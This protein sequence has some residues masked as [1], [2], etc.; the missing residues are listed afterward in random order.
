MLAGATVRLIGYVAGDDAIG[1]VIPGGISHTWDPVA[2]V[3]QFSGAA[4]VAQYQ[5]LL[6]SVTYK[7][8]R[9]NPTTS[10]RA[11]EFTISDGMAVSTPV[12]VSISVTAVNNPPTLGAPTTQ[13]IVENTSLVLSMASGNAITVGDV[14]A[15][16]NPE[17]VTLAATDGSFT[18]SETSG[19]NFSVGTGANDMTAVFTGTLGDINAALDGLTFV[20]AT[21]YAGPARID[22][23]INDRGHA[24]IGGPLTASATVAIDVA[25]L[26][27]PPALSLPALQTLVEGTELVFSQANSNGLVASD[28]DSAG[29][30]EQLSLSATG[31]TLRLAAT[32]GLHF[33][34]GSG[35]G[36]ATI[37]ISGTLADLNAAID[38]LIFTPAAGYSGFA[39][40]QVSINDQ[41]N[42]G[43]GGPLTAQ[44]VIGITITPATAAP[45]LWI[46]EGL[47]TLQDTP[48]V[49]SQSDG[50]GITLNDADA[51][52]G[53]DQ[54]ALTATGGTLTLASTAGLNFS[55]GAGT[56]DGNVTFSGTVA[57]LNAALDGLIFKPSTGY[58]GPATIQVYFAD[59]DDANGATPLIANGTV[60]INI[61]PVNHA[62]VLSQDGIA[63]LPPVD[64]DAANPPGQNVLEMISTG[65]ADPIS[66]IDANSLQ[67]IAI[68]GQSIPAGGQWQFMLPGGAWMNLGDV[69][70]TGATLLP[71]SASVRFIPPGQ[72]SGSATLSYRA[73]DQTGGQPGDVQAD[74]TVNGGTSAFSAATA[75]ASVEVLPAAAPLPPELIVNNGLQAPPAASAPITASMLQASGPTGTP[76]DVIFT[77]TIAPAH[78]YLKVGTLR[79]IAGT[80][81]TQGDINSGRVTYASNNAGSPYDDFTFVVSDSAGD[82][83]APA[84]FGIHVGNARAL[85]PVIPALPSASIGT[86]LGGTSSG[87]TPSTAAGLAL[88]GASQTVGSGNPPE[89]LLVAGSDVSSNGGSSAH[90]TSGSSAAL[91]GNSADRAALALAPIVAGAGVNRPLS[92]PVQRALPGAPV[93]AAAPVVVPQLNL[94]LANLA[95]LGTSQHGSGMMLLQATV[96]P[97]EALTRLA[98]LAGNHSSY[99]ADGTN[100]YAINQ[101]SPFWRDL[102]DMQQQMN[103]DH[104]LRIVAGSAAISVG[105]SVMY[106]V[107]V[108]RAGSILSSFLSSMPA[109]RLVDPLPILDSMG[110]PSGSRAPK[111]N[112]EEDEDDDQTLESLVEGR[113]RR[114]D[115]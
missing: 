56:N 33:L 101:A 59:L 99:R 47:S 85:P 17:Q 103:A 57:D 40:I 82:S 84:V 69:S 7:N 73:W 42:S 49:L 23:S 90:A 88:S 115:A 54:L 77:V 114:P 34:I 64:Q 10:S 53:A 112:G 105:V 102:D 97:D 44:G 60:A 15:G 110:G 81:F 92:L 19:L 4:S 13:T 31:G 28:A 96:T 80:T 100:S 5:T 16:G 37:S 29:N 14:D 2:G 8:I 93:A 68:I 18:L 91:S 35:G 43:V 50:S 61:A 106:L 11:A 107:W 3:I 12:D 111:P 9:Q 62:P 104:R 48:L 25:P 89:N 113:T 45:S 87:W 20:P 22:V 27:H 41:G 108:L 36:G 39:T 78:G 98:L 94:G 38:G 32:T 46:P 76:E 51:S 30:P 79:V 86:T 55:Q 65:G 52:A 74:T 63:A 71:T 70:D 67:G 72:W 109:W 83:L 75:S 26:N 58:T 6:R 21:G 1:F 95:D 66:D 24:G